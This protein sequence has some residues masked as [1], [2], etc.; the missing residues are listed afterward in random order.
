ML[1]KIIKLGTP[2]PRTPLTFLSPSGDTHILEFHTAKGM[3]SLLTPQE[4]HLCARISPESLWAHHV[5]FCLS[6]PAR[7]DGHHVGTSRDLS[8]S[9]LG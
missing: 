6:L 4:V 7:L 3:D 9:R 1:K 8:C 2:A 5:Y